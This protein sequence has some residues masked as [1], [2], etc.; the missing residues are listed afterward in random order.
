V[1]RRSLA[2]GTGVGRAD[3]EDPEPVV[4]RSGSIWVTVWPVKNIAGI[5]PR[6]CRGAQTVRARAASAGVR[7]NP[8]TV[9][10]SRENRSRRRRFF[11]VRFGRHDLDGR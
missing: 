2:A 3:G 11:T 8:G 10:L 9:C 6:Y 1:G 5:G 4:G 7:A